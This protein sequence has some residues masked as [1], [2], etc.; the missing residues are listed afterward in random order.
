MVS[1]TADPVWK[2]DMFYMK[3][4]SRGSVYWGAF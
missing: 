3:V 2:G 1:I 4:I